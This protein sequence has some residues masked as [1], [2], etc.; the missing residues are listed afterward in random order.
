MPLFN[1]LGSTNSYNVKGFGA[2]GDGIT[3]DTAAIQSAL[4][5]SLT[6]GY[7]VVLPQGEY[8]VRSLN[9]RYGQKL[10]GIGSPTL[11]Q[12]ANTSNFNP[13]ITTG[14]S[15]WSA[16]SPTEDSP[17]L[18]ISGIQFD[19]NQLNQGTYTGFQ[20]QHNSAIFLQGN[21]SDEEGGYRLRAVVENCT[22][23][24]TCGDG[25]TVWLGVDVSVSD[26][27]FWNCFRG[28]VVQIGGNSVV[29]S[30]NISCGGDRHNSFYQ[31]EIEGEGRGE[32]ILTNSYFDHLKG[33]PSGGTGLDF[34]M[35]NNSNV[36]VSNCYFGA[37]VYRVDSNTTSNFTFNNCIFRIKDTDIAV[38][39]GQTRFSYCMFLVQDGHTN[40]LNFRGYGEEGLNTLIENCT[41]RFEV[42]PLTAVTPMNITNASVTGSSLSITL[43]AAHGITAPGNYGFTLVYLTGF[44]PSSYNGAYYVSAVP[45]STELT[46]AIQK[47]YGAITLSSAT[48]KII[49]ESAAISMS[50]G[51]LTSNS[52]TVRGCTF[53]SGFKYAYKMPQGGTVNF[54]DNSV[55]AYVLGYFASNA[56]LPGKVRLAG[57]KFLDECRVHFALEATGGASTVDMVLDEYVPVR[58]SFTRRFI[59]VD[60]LTLNGHR[61][62]YDNAAPVTTQVK[63]TGDTFE[64]TAASLGYPHAYLNTGGYTTND[65]WRQMQHTVGMGTTAN[66]PVLDTQAV[67]VVYLDTTLNA[68]GQPIRW[69]GTGWV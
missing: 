48:A 7:A 35:G 22:I 14:S 69:T 1:I 53:D 68:N 10:I 15:L 16:T 20:K 60:G 52:I 5:L 64:N 54:Y 23:K 59:D 63:F 41:F 47:S 49:P 44:T 37:G 19:G 13:I 43:D 58:A 3:D 2:I 18:Y 66:R 29:R 62:L 55:N 28:S 36:T 21:S 17:L 32:N 12:K 4:T 39:Y 30:N 40:A 25:V 56:S 57:N 50:I 8:I 27:F 31:A 65:T 11:K 24:N 67:G 61:T 6:T 34:I 33:N 38:Q 42:D 9:M 26:C 45:S 51:E 46:L